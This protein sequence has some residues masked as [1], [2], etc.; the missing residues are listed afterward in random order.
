MSD[1]QVAVIVGVGPGLGFALVRRFARAGMAVAAGARSKERL[2]ELLAGEPVEG[3]RAYACDATD[4]AA[5]DRLFAQVEQDLGAPEVMV[6]NA[7]AFRPGGILEIDPGDFEQ[8]WRIGCFAGFL[9][10]QAAA[11]RMVAQG[12]GTILFTGATAARRGSARFANLAVPKFGLRALAQ[13][14]ARELGP[15]GVH[16]GHV[17]IDGQILSER[18]AHL[19]AGRG[20]DALLEPDA[21]AEMYYQLHAQPRSAWTLELDLRPWSEK[22]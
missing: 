18:Y 10:G 17:I 9:V 2:E 11:R 12:H 7:G 6:F 5:V 1:R 19:A 16:V 20:P 15:Q 14:M 13:S 22:F 3:A 4:R 21:I 8:C